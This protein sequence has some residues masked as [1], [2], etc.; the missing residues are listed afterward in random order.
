VI[1]WVIIAII[2]IVVLALILYHVLPVVSA[3]RAI[4]QQEPEP[5]GHPGEVEGKGEQD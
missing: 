3:V 2:A 4:F 1:K 5:T